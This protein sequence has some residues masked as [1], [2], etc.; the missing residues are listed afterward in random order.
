MRFAATISYIP[1]AEDWA[2]IKAILDYAITNIERI[3]SI[4]R[5]EECMRMYVGDYDDMHTLTFVH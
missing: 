3:K 5:V 1:R 4:Q 2:S